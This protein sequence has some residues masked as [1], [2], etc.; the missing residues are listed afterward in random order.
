MRARW[1]CGVVL[2][3]MCCVSVAAAAEKKG[4]LL[5]PVSG[6][7]AKLSVMKA[8]DEGP[9][10]F[11][12][13]GC[14]KKYEAKP[15]DYKEKV[16]AQQEVIAHYPKIQEKCPVSGEALTSKK[17]SLETGGT[18][19]YFCCNGCIDKY[20]ADAKKYKASLAAS[21]KYLEPPMCPVS[22][23]PADLSR[24]LTTDSGPVYLCCGGC[25]KAYKADPAKYAD[26][27]KVQ[28]TALAA[29]N[30][31]QVNCPVSGKPVSSKQFIEKDGKKVSFC[32]ADCKGAYEKDSV[33]Y[34]A[35]LENSYTYQTICPVMDD[36]IV[37][38]IFVETTD[39][40]KVYVCCRGC[41][42]KLVDKPE[43]Y[44][45]KLEEQGVHIEADQFKKGG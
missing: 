37:P 22:G 30:R 13:E 27:V 41:T 8:T 12:C 15:A 44:L 45:S 40:R 10:F 34:A 2:A 32:C 17:S 14:V 43:K 5:C 39:G 20:K 7:P 33:K 28:R 23:K 11:C 35:K 42:N 36:E 9:A 21:Y 31:V 26:K 3:A 18:T 29:M 1:G 25:E 24:L 16:A 4:G 19:V 38:S 6:E